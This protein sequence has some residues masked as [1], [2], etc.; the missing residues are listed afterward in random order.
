LHLTVRL[1]FHWANEFFDEAVVLR[2]RGNGVEVLARAVKY[3]PHNL[4]QSVHR[5]VGGLAQVVQRR[6]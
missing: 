3:G 1:Q 4:G 5:V 2:R 6:L